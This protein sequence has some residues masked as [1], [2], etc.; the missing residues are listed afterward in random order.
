MHV[1]GVN[2]TIDALLQG[3]RKIPQDLERVRAIGDGRIGSGTYPKA[4]N[5]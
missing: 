4:R 5:G 2:V 1:P 3:P